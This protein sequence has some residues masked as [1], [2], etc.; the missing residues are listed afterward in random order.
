MSQIDE[1]KNALKIDW[2]ISLQ[3]ISFIDKEFNEFYYFFE[4]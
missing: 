4:A 2:K 3:F 1:K